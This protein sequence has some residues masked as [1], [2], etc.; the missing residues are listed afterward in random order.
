MDCLLF[1]DMSHFATADI[2]TDTGLTFARIE[3]NMRWLSSKF[4]SGAIKFDQ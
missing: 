1:G 4:T 3:A 2:F